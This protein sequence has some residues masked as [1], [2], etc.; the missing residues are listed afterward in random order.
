MIVRRGV[1]EVDYRV[2]APDPQTRWIMEEAFHLAAEKGWGTSRIAKHLN[3]EARIPQSLKP[4]HAATIGTWLDNEIYYGE[5]VWGKT[6]TGIVNDVRVV[7]SRPQEDW[8]RIP[9]FCEA[10]V[11]REVWDQV[12]TLREERR[13]RRRKAR[14][15]NRSDAEEL[16]GLRVP[17]IALNYLLTG[18]V[19]CRECGRSMAP[20]SSAVYR[21]KAGEERRYVSYYCPAHAAGACTNGR[22]VPEKWLRETVVALIRQRLFLDE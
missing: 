19:R 9:E 13:R 15:S 10:L 18:L 21:T 14:P 17:G 3:A 2:L 20:S 22:G 7:Q 6:C 5:L 8:E 1:E 12:Q 16:P 11:S 4:F